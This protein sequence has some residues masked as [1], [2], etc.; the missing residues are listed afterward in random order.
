MG[1]NTGHDLTR[2][3]YVREVD[4]FDAE[5]FAIEEADFWRSVDSGEYFEPSGEVLDRMDAKG[6]DDE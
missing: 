5:K 4:G 3:D 6:A 1:G 2:Y